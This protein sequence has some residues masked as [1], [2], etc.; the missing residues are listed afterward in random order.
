MCLD[1]PSA[2]AVIVQAVFGFGPGLDC[3]LEG[4]YF[5]LYVAN[6]IQLW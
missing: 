4:W 3:K 5:R 2:N 1:L 6:I